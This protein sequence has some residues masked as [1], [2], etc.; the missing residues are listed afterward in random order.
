[1]C[2]KVRSQRLRPARFLGFSQT[3]Y[4]CTADRGTAHILEFDSSSASVECRQTLLQKSAAVTDAAG[5]HAA[6]HD[7]SVDEL[8]A[9]MKA[10]GFSTYLAEAEAV[11]SRRSALRLPGLLPN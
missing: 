10:P 7:V 9:L 11:L 6:S 3:R 2:Q 4:A 5:S 1:M 8:E